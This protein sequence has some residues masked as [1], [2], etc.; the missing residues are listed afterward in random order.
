MLGMNLFPEHRGHECIWRRTF[1]NPK[2]TFGNISRSDQRN[3]AHLNELSLES[4]EEHHKFSLSRK[5]HLTFSME[6][7]ISEIGSVRINQFN[8]FWCQAKMK[9][10]PLSLMMMEIPVTTWWLFDVRDNDSWSNWYFH[11]FLWL[12]FRGKV[13]EHR[14]IDSDWAHG[15]PSYPRRR[16][17]V[18]SC[19]WEGS[20]VGILS[21]CVSPFWSIVNCRR[22][23]YRSSSVTWLLRR[24]SSFVRRVSH[25]LVVDDSGTCILNWVVNPSPWQYHC[26]K[27]KRIV[28]N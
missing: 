6:D 20:Q 5:R 12:R 24:K 1:F 16:K 8:L 17:R 23:G 18:H 3:S 10:I 25:V 13:F 11:N 9:V 4:M 26:V 19:S 2:L 22:G 14:H 21:M 15:T 28:R 7:L 27:C